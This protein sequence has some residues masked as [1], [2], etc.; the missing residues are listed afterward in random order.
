[1]PGQTIHLAVAHAFS[2]EASGE[3][4]FANM[5]PDYTDAR[6]IKDIIHLRREPDRHEALCE[7]RE[8]IDRK[9]DFQFG[10]LLH[11][12]AD[13]KWDTTVIP[14]FE[15]TYAGE[16]YWFYSYRAEL[17]KLSRLMYRS[18]P[19]VP[20]VWEKIEAA[21]FTDIYDLSRVLPV[22]LELNWFREHVKR[23]HTAV[24]EDDTPK[25]F[26]IDMALT[27]AEKTAKQFANFIKITK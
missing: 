25:Y 2:P 18:L 1:M 26:S 3:F 17:G 9:N 15:K 13:W 8:R 5:A 20:A 24:H 16:D 6:A 10:W 27:F 12:F 19:W 21:D 14:E 4:Y 7:L 22:P 11:L 23:H